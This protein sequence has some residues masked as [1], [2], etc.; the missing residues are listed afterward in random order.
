MTSSIGILRQSQWWMCPVL[1]G[2]LLVLPV[3][4]TAQQVAQPPA[5][6]KP[7]T[8]LPTTQSLR[9]IA[10]AGNEERNDL[11]RGVMGRLVVQVLDLNGKPVEG[12]A[13]VFRFPV[14]GP[15]A[16]FPEAKNS[17]TAQ[18]NADGQ[19]AATGWVANRQMGRFEV[20]ISASKD[21]EIGDATVTMYNVAD[22]EAAEKA[23]RKKS[24]WSSRWTR[25]GLLAGA[26]A[27]AGLGVWLARRGGPAAP[28][29]ILTPGAP[30]IGGAR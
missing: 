17:H 26:G 15:S 18:T 19:A 27:G 1:A 28:T 6:A 14:S 24:I 22:A 29:V 21:H 3:Q 23:S 7:L 11:R 25:L 12:A 9:V 20:K 16:L 4:S 13:V 10:L 30:N 5:S 2:T 8:P